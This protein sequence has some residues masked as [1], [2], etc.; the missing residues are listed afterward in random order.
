[1][2]LL[3]GWFV[4]AIGSLFLAPA[5]ARGQVAD[6][7]SLAGVVRDASG[8]VLPGVTVEAASPALIEKVRTVVSDGQGIYRIVDLRPGVYTVTFTLPGFTSFRREGLALTT[9]FTATV[10]AELKVGALE[11]T[12]TVTGESPVVDISN[13]RQQT[14]LERSTL[15]A[16]PTT[17][18]LATYAQI[19]P[20]ATYGSA[21]WQSVGGLDERGNAF[22]IHGS[23]A[24]DNVPVMN[25]LAQRLQGGAIFV[26]NNLTFEEVV[27]ETGGMSAERSTGGVQMNIVPKDGGNTF[28]GSFST[29]HSSPSW[30]AGNLTDELRQRGLSFSPSLKQ[31]YD[32]GGALGGPIVRDRLWFFNAYR[33]GGNQQYQQG[34]YFNKL[35]DVNVSA[36]P[37]YRVTF[38]EPDLDRPG[39]TNDFYR[40]YSLRLTWQAARLHKIVASYQVQPNCSC[41]WP[42]LELGPQQGIQGTPEA[43]GAHNYKVNYLP[44]VTWTYPATNRLLLEAGASANVF[45]NNTLRT[46]PS[47]GLD[48]IAITEL[49]GNFRYGSRALGTSHAQGYRVQHNRQYRQRVSMSYITGSHAF[50]AGL[51]T[52][53]YREGSP[54]K[55]MDSNQI[56][57]ARSYAFRN[58]IPQQVTIYAVPFEQLWRT[59]DVAAYVQ[60]QWT[61]RRLTLNLGVRINKFNGGASATE[62][63]AGPFV[64]ARS[65]PETKDSPNWTNV[66][67]RL[68]VAYDLFGNGRTALKA[69]LGRFTRYE[70]A[71]VN[72]PAANQASSTTRTWNDGNLNYVP[73]CDLRS[74]VANG[75]CGPWS[76]LT[77]GQ[78]RGGNTSRADDAREGFNRQLGNWQASVSL[79]HELRANLA[80]NVGY[81]RTWHRGFLVLDN[82]AVTP[83]DY[84]PFCVTVPRDSRLPGGG[85]NEI[86]GLYD[87]KPT[88]FG[89]VSNLETQASNYGGQTEI[90]NGI[91]V[92]LNAR[93]SSGAQVGGGLSAG[94][95]VS[96]TCALNAVPQVRVSTLDGA[97]VA[98][99]A[100]LVSRTSEF[101]RTTRPW[102]DATQVKFLA[103]YPLPWDFQVSATYQNIPGIPIMASRVFTN[104]EVRSSL[105]RDL[106][107]CRGAAACNATALVDMVPSG[108][109]FE[110]RLQQVDLRFT[111][112]FRLA[113]ARIRGNAD[114]YNL[115]NAGDVLN[116]TT[117][118]AGA[119]GGQWLRP[120][121]IL[122]GRM[123]KFSAQ[124][125]F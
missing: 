72:V 15:D 75:E 1:M 9:G 20:G 104:A 100:P 81:F 2:R 32:T 53:Q 36:D 52:S 60:D 16:L 47:V 118:Y 4:V 56:N 44:L 111:R 71:A 11:E 92:T 27:V 82:Q 83:A 24:E 29:S 21:V 88:A 64:P 68:G 34:N 90:Y 117:R 12:I 42:L 55:A 19:I 69:S 125:D 73:D 97:A 119:T 115:F 62:M 59:H 26:F 121:Q 77:F 94:R 112:S 85:G 49:S 43:V 23:R 37:V 116:M 18:R 70:I 79:Q 93:F 46:D 28:S 106:G 108:T 95:T 102:A 114:F 51:E 30:Q 7:A 10:N 113:R 99:T 6:T 41:F 109:M 22:G 14:T 96:D 63:P 25:G 45:D 58:R 50:K 124:L 65:F 67:P 3:S 87:V 66:N 61:V 107:A 120:I 38:Y 48:T 91:D 98:A 39:H 17:G 13:V 74:P 5:A 86:C 31:H 35:Q 84:D 105:G 103:I 89:R 8:G 122:G 80:L 123:F 78:V 110:D 54:G 76:D 101:C 33:F 40:D 57:G